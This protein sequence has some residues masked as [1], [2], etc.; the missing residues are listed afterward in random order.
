MDTGIPAHLTLALLAAGASQRMGKP[1]QLIQWKGKSL[2]QHA[3]DNLPNLPEGKKC[4]VLGSYAS[5]IQKDSALAGV[6]VL[7]NTAWKEGMAASIRTAVQY[8]SSQQASALF[9][10]LADQPYVTRHHY[11]QLMEAHQQHPDH[12]IAAA[13]QGRFGAP[14]IFPVR[15]FPKLM[16]LNGDRGAGSWVNALTAGVTGVPMPEAGEDWDTPAD[17]PPGV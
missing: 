11:L 14:M 4:L 12:I 7:Y 2:L 3:L 5:E 10:A 15:Y 16:D 8:A 9:I 17:L 13:Y 6:K 1:K